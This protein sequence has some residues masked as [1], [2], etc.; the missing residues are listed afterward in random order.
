MEQPA[1][2]IKP[3]NAP[4]AE[5]LNMVGMRSFVFPFFQRLPL[6]PAAGSSTM[7]EPLPCISFWT[8][9]RTWEMEN[10]PIRMGV[11]SKPSS[12]QRCPKVK[13]DTPVMES[14]PIQPTSRPKRAEKI[15]F[16][17]LS[18]V[19]PATTRTP[20]QATRKYSSTENIWL[21]FPSA[22]AKRIRQMAPMIPPRTE[23]TVT[24]EIASMPW[25]FFVIS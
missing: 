21:I 5:L 15:P 2:G 14:I 3:T 16:A 20:K 24:T 19:R 6:R 13:R 11:E 18:P 9:T 1:A 4:M 7:V 12:S 22:G 25:P 8:S 10:R 17:W 23:A